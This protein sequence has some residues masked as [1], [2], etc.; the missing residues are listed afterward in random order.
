M[1]I[2]QL[3]ED[4]A[5]HTLQ[6]TF[7]LYNGKPC[8]IRRLDVDDVTVM[9]ITTGSNINIEATYF[10]GWKE[11]KYPRL[12]YRKLDNGLWGWVN[13][14]PRSYTRG[15]NSENVHLS[16][17][18][19]LQEDAGQDWFVREHEFHPYAFSDMVYESTASAHALMRAALT[20]VWDRGDKLLQVLK[21]GA[22]SFIPSE[23]FLVEPLPRSKKFGVY[24]AN[25]LIGRIDS[26]LSVFAPKKNIRIIEDMVKRYAA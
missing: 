15:L 16:L 10:S 26:D 3:G 1:L 24:M 2:D 4:Y 6:G 18:P 21:G 17:S 20:P 7:F 11:L 9:D 19:Y 25:T 22:K 14:T 12:G 13:R 8:V 23:R 5:S